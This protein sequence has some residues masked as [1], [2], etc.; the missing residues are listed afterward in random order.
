[1]L[2]AAGEVLRTCF[3][4]SQTK[5]SKLRQL[6]FHI[7]CQDESDILLLVLLSLDFWHH[8]FP[9][10]PRLHSTPLTA[11]L[12][13]RSSCYHVHVCDLPARLRLSSSSSSNYPH[14]AIVDQRNQSQPLSASASAIRVLSKVLS[15]ESSNFQSSNPSPNNQTYLLCHYSPPQSL[16]LFLSSTNSGSSGCIT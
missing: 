10:Q 5:M 12:L 14:H 15:A 16:H 1:M 6:P 13:R 3:S 7:L 8:R 4:L 2:L 11:L 9:D